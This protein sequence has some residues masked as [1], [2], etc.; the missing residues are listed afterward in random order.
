[1]QPKRLQQNVKASLNSTYFLV[2]SLLEQKRVL[3][4]YVADHDLPMTLTANQWALL[5][6]IMAMTPFEELTRKVSLCT[7]DVIPAVTILK[8]IQAK[9]D[10]ADSGIKTMKTA[11]L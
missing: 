7:A 4:A 2:E 1:M 8:P 5:E 6:N 9:E 10:E 3:C 11:L